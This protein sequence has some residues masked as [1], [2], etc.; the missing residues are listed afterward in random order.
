M[1]NIKVQCPA[2]INLSLKIKGKRP[3]GFHEIES[4]MQTISLYDYLTIEVAEN[5]NN[6]IE[7]SGNNSQIPYDNKN[8]AY[9][10]TELFFH[11]TKINNTKTKSIRMKLLY[12]KIF[13]LNS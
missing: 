1:K 6:S 13:I 3:D 8:L 10:A 11:T 9:K 4:I 7:L 2:K 12:F 5:T